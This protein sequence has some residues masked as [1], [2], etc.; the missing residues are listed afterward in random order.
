[1][2]FIKYIVLV[3]IFAP[4]SVSAQTNPNAIVEDAV[5][6]Y[7]ADAPI[8]ID[9]ARCETGFR[10][11]K[12]DG[13]PVYDPTGTYVGIFQ[14]A[15]RIHSPKATAMGFD[16]R[17]IDGNLRYT[18]YLYENSGTNPWKGCLPKVSTPSPI[19]VAV[20][21]SITT[22]L[23]MG[24]TSSQVLTLQQILNKT[25][26]TISVSGPGSPGSE[27]RYFGSLTREA[28]RKFQCAKEIV[29]SGDEATTGYGR[30]GPKTRS[31][32]NSL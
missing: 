16:V 3:A 1:M 23:R 26:F 20:T 15:E 6:F 9:I 14:I 10:Q 19:P 32:L 24:M 11:Y 5:R 22:I 21:G 25:G 13:S 17:T 4:I 27:T 18:R 12:A 8:M 30:I 29:C 28:V 2:K 31:V 7:F